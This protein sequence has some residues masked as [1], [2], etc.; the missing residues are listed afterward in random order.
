M[1]LHIRDK[2]TFCKLVF[3]VANDGGLKLQDN[4]EAERD[5]GDTV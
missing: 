4:G 3:E 1:Y 5:G 2:I